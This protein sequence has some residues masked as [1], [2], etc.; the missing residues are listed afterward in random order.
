MKKYNVAVVGASGLVGRT[1]VK[2]LEERNLPIENLKLLASKN[3]AGMH[4]SFR[5]KDYHVHELTKD[6]FVDVDFAL[7]SAGSD[8]SKEFAPIA[9]EAGC[10]VIDNSSA[11]RLVD[12]IPLVVPEVNPEDLRNHKNIIANPNCSTIQMLAAIKPVIDKY[13]LERLVCSTYQSISGAGQKGVDKLIGEIT[14]QSYSEG[15]HRIAFNAIFHASNGDGFTDEEHKMVHE[16]R[17]M[18]HAPELRLAMTCVR[19]PL[20][21]GHGESLN[22]ELS[23]EFELDDIREL[24]SNT[25]GLVLV[26]DIDNEEYPTPLHATG[27]DE[28][29]VG[30]LR[31]DDSAPNGLYMWVVADNLR[32]GA[33][34]NAVQIAQ[35][36]I[37]MELV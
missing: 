28:V 11:W 27:R 30:R 16:T 35:K 21:G 13:G 25:E 15:K 14:D 20:L 4:I 29:F 7:F 34:T 22:L 19:L 36:L 31:R 12:G 33:A 18:L 37:E 2:V 17:K 26:D 23:K 24:I 9:A 10:V 8:V 32:K 5:G 3:S 1:M 6:S